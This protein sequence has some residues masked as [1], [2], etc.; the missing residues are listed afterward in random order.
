LANLLLGGAVGG[1]NTAINNYLYFEDKNVGVGASIGAV[2]G[3]AGGYIGNGISNVSSTLLPY[4]I[5]GVM[6]DPNKSILLQN[7]GVKN[8]YPAYIGEAAGGATSGGLP[9]LFE[10]VQRKR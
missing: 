2:A 10:E 3:L 5:G 7:I 8:P 6:I 9:I 1:T 4:R